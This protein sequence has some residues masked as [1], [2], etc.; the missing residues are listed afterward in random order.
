MNTR[1]L[2]MAVAVLLV[3]SACATGK[4][5]V[6]ELTTK[7][8]SAEELYVAKSYA[9]NG[10][11]PTFSERR[12][13]EA[14]V[15]ERV[16]KYLREHPEMEQTTRYSDFRFWWQVSTGSTP[17][18]VRVLLEEPS[19]QTIDPV[20]MARLAGP[21]W[22]QIQDKAKEAWFYSPAWVIYFDETG[23]VAIIHK[24]SSMAPTQY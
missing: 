6:D 12:L 4:L 14:D 13:W 19:E 8:P 9:V 18:E 20:L 2:V 7:G 22:G 17:A 1:L 15:E 11:K 21:Q 3:A 23:V 5:D 10:R 24:V 16:F